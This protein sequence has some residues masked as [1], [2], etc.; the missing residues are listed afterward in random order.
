MTQQITVRIAEKQDLAGIAQLEKA[1]FVHPWQYDDLLDSFLGCVTF[2]IARLDQ[3]II[4][5]VGVQISLDEGYITNV[6]VEPTA[7]RNGVGRALMAGLSAFA[8]RSGIKELSLE[9]RPSNH[10]ALQLYKSVGFA[11][12]GRRKNFYSD[13]REDALILNKSIHAITPPMDTEEPEIS[14]ISEIL[15]KL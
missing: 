11:E 7:R 14:K 15:E 1:C 5:Y 8:A 2:L 9:V 13:P 6:A 4:G 10:G 3:K 12:V